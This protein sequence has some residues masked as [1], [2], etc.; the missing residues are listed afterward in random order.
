MARIPS[1][2]AAIIGRRLAEARTT[3][4]ATQ[5]DIAYHARVDLPSLNEYEKGRAM[6]QI[7]TLVRLA[8]ALGIDPGELI[9]GLDWSSFPQDRE[10][11]IRFGGKPARKRA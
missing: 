9:A 11:P 10:P 2:A 7:G 3:I 8:A 5:Q 1:E 4:N 6:P